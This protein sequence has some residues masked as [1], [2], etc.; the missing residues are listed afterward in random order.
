MAGSVALTTRASSA[1]RGPAFENAGS[2]ARE[3]NKNKRQSALCLT[4]YLHDCHCESVIAAVSLHNCTLRIIFSHAAGECW[5]FVLTDCWADQ[6]FIQRLGGFFSDQPQ[7]G[8]LPL[9]PPTLFHI[10]PA[11]ETT[12]FFGS[13]V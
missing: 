8:N 3:F 5:W 9:T 1:E 13:G 12:R 6:A 2:F 7:I 4:P 10:I 11:V